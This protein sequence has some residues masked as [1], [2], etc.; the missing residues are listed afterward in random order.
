MS[1][2]EVKNPPDVDS[3][4]L[5]DDKES[6]ARH[7]D[8]EIK[9]P[10]WNEKNELVDPELSA[11]FA[12]ESDRVLN[13]KRDADGKVAPNAEPILLR[14]KDDPDPAEVQRLPSQTED[15]NENPRPINQDYLRPTPIGAPPNRLIRTATGLAGLTPDGDTVALP[16]DF[17]PESSERIVGSELPEMPFDQKASDDALKSTENP[18]EDTKAPS[19]DPNASKGPETANP[20]PSDADVNKALADLDATGIKKP[21]N[22]K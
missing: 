11:H 16:T 18:Q 17:G 7:R 22:D 13:Q 19:D 10:I 8:S 6:M 20:G 15:V 2:E 14:G 12:E 9:N 21:K 1:N 5:S 3:A 4:P